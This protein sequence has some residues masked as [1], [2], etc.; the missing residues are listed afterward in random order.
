MGLKNAPNAKE[1]SSNLGYEGAYQLQFQKAVT[2]WWIGRSKESRD[3]FIKLVNQGPTLSERYQ[4]M[5]QSNITSLGSGPD[6][7]LRYHK[8]FYDQLRH[9]FPGAETIEKNFSQT[10]QDMF[11]L[12]MLNGK[13]NGTYFEIGA[14]DP[15]HGSNTALLEQF[16]WTG[17]SLEI[18]PHEVEKKMGNKRQGSTTKTQDYDSNTKRNKERRLYMCKYPPPYRI[19]W[20]PPARGSCHS[21]WQ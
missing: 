10:Y 21:G 14:A 8:G 4:K 20:R 13:R 16:G 11:T 3:E 6:P 12:S 7:F 17:T 2:A 1:V 5:V 9:K 19:S 18:L 15:F